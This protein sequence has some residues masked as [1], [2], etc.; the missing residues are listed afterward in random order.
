MVI[1]MEI[2]N[3]LTEVLIAMIIMSSNSDLYFRALHL[4][5]I[6]FFSVPR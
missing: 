5:V 2:D 3:L 6:H 1:W 4:F